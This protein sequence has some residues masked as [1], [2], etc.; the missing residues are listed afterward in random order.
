[1]KGYDTYRIEIEPLSS[2]LTP[3]H[4]DTIFGHMVWALS[5]L[6]GKDEADDLD[7]TQKKR[8]RSLALQTKELLL[9]QHRQK[10]D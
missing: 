2:F 1:M 9:K 4:S 8:L 6:Y 7:A 5:D 10:K 3:F